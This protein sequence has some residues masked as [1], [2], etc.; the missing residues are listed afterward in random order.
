MK[1]SR[2]HATNINPDRIFAKSYEN[3]EN[4]RFNDT[5]FERNIYSLKRVHCYYNNHSNDS[6]KRI[7]FPSAFRMRRADFVAATRRSIRIRTFP[8]TFSSAMR[9]KVHSGQSGVSS[10]R[11]EIVSWLRNS[12]PERLGPSL[13]SVRGRSFAHSKRNPIVPFLS[14]RQFPRNPV[15]VRNAGYGRSSL[16][17][18]WLYRDRNVYCLSN[19]ICP[20]MIWFK[21]DIWLL[22]CKK[23]VSIGVVSFMFQFRFAFVILYRTN[24]YFKIWNGPY[25]ITFTFNGWRALYARKV[26]RKY[27]FYFLYCVLN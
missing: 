4:L 10:A 16:N 20:I 2:K 27:L 12:K 25:S 26:Q 19:D 8:C 11:F 23:M 22:E 3:I 18:T 9:R 1:F 17:G 21:A 7:Q 5:T 14:R 15:C 13:Y 24:Q 6:P